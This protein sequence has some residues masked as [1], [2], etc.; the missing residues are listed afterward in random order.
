MSLA[1]LNSLHCH[2]KAE[3][4]KANLSIR[5]LPDKVW[6]YLWAIF[7]KILRMIFP[8]RVLG[9]PGALHSKRSDILATLTIT[10]KQV[11]KTVRTP[12]LPISMALPY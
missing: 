8:D 9:R 4:Q 3:V 2:E 12:S 1:F 11:K 10:E 5:R 6:A 7:R